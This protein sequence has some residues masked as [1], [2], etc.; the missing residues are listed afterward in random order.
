MENS[1]VLTPWNPYYIVGE[2][3][4]AGHSAYPSVPLF[5]FLFACYIG[6]YWLSFL[7]FSFHQTP[8]VQ[9][10]SYPSPTYSSLN[11]KILQYIIFFTQ[12]NL[13]IQVITSFFP[14]AIPKPFVPIIIWIGIAQYVIQG[15]PWEIRKLLKLQHMH[16]FIHLQYDILAII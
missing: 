8:H 15:S 2:T 12:Y 1:Q 6:W 13:I 14:V 11:K 16:L 10:F 3:D 5:S 7:S 4:V 9:P